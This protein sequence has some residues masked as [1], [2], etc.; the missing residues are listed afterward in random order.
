MALIYIMKEEKSPS[1][2][3]IYSEEVLGDSTFNYNTSRVVPKTSELT[4]LELPFIHWQ[5]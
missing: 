1:N 5:R 3:H 4:Q 2:M